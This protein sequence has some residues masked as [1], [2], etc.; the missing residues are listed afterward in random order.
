MAHNPFAGIEAAPEALARH[1]VGRIFTEIPQYSR[2]GQASLYDDVYDQCLQHALLL[3]AIL[4]A[5]RAPNRDD[6]AFARQAAER[7]AAARLPLDAFLHAFR[8]THSVM[9][10]RIAETGDAEAA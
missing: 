7:R 4:R 10:T 3:P 2:L 5:G 9:W 8:V 1:M 6:F